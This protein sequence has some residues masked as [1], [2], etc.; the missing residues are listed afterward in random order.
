MFVDFTHP[1]RLWLI[2]AG[3][4]AVTVLAV[5]WRTGSRKQRISQG[6]RY[7]LILLTALSLAGTGV[8]TPSPDRATWL[9]LDAS[10]SMDA[11]E[12]LRL[13]REALGSAGEDRT[14]GVI[15]FG[16]NASV[17]KSL[18]HQPTLDTISSRTDAGGSRLGEA[19][20]LAEALLPTEVNGSIAVIS[21]GLTD[22]TEW[23]GHG[24]LIPINVLKTERKGNRDAQVTA[25]KAPASLYEGQKYTTRVTVHASESGTATLLL[26]RNHQAA[27]GREVALRPGENIFDFETVAEE[28]GIIPTEARIVLEGDT[29][30]ENDEG[31]AFSVVSGKPGVLI[32]EGSAGAGQELKKMLEAASMRAETISAVAMPE[33][34]SG[35][36]EY[37][38][39]ALV[40]VDA[41]QLNR[42]QLQALNSAVRELGRG[43]AV[44]GG[45]QSYALG[46]YRGSELEELLPVTI[47][48]RNRMDLP[49]TALVLCIDKSGSM[50]DASYGVSRLALAREAACSALDILNERDQAG[51]IAFDDEGK[52][53]V[54]LSNLTNREDMQ[55]QIATVRPGGGTA[56]FTPLAM[57]MQ[58][59]RNTTA[60]YKHVIFLSDGEAGDR[61]YER[62][63]EEMHQ[64]G[65]TL[66]T[67]AVGE[68][69]DA[70]G[71]RRLA[72]L[73]NG[74]AYAAGPFDS[75]PKIFTKETMLVSEAYVQNRVFIPRITDESLTGFPGFPALS[76]YLVTTEKPL[77]TVCLISDRKDPILAWQQTGAGRTLA[78]TSDIQGA[79]SASYL[80][81]E[82]GAEF[83]S[84][85]ISFLLPTGEMGGQMEVKDGQI[86]YIVDSAAEGFLAEAAVTRPD[87]STDRVKLEQVSSTGYEGRTDTGLTGVY[88]VQVTLTDGETERTVLG[89]DV[90]SWTEEYDQRKRDDGAQEAICEASGGKIC[91]EPGELLDFTDTKARKRTD[92]TPWLMTAAAFL[93]LFDIAQRRLELFREPQGRQNGQDD[94][95]NGKSGKKQQRKK[96]TAKKPE[97]KPGQATEKLWQNMQNRKKL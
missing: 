64:S 66:T 92:L 41:D 87:G 8:Q 69:S 84:G 19:L 58:A 26:S 63:A 78:W 65:I 50:T 22:E 42:K 68:G 59:L 18:Q 80:Q 14:V 29:V 23:T 5:I 15:L 70:A 2:P 82:Q 91:T 38:A 6:I 39:V 51:V 74:R 79:W 89:G 27:F 49:T 83:F 52:W 77:A 25:V 88:T 90:V 20:A 34:T 75:L 96:K 97:E 55:K 61:N 33:E 85:L 12:G 21:D 3:V 40:N 35:Y 46:G 7:A 1:I 24:E 47:D 93:F 81:W 30:P 48:V 56:F 57:A 37:H 60:Q 10:A 71:L 54:P 44:F 32:A 16:K 9:L 86:R 45:D 43:L 11:Q 36:L 73:G 53:V 28:S 17:E 67:V 4:I 76:G 62:L 72:E 94:G 31:G 13:A 95:D